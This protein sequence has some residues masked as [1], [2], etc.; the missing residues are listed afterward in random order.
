[1]AVSG[2]YSW[3]MC[4]PSYS[5]KVKAWGPTFLRRE[6]EIGKE[7]TGSCVYYRVGTVVPCDELR[8]SAHSRDFLTCTQLGQVPISHNSIFYTRLN[9]K[10]P[11][12]APPPPLLPPP[13]P[14]PPP[15]PT[16]PLTLLSSNIR[17][18]P[19]APTN[20]L[21]PPLSRSSLALPEP[22]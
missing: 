8:V 17:D 3:Y 19:P 7:G 9:Q 5:Y 1:M 18:F 20:S 4:T 2:M 6:K 14:P 13:P 22:A 12:A 16:P 11:Q 10:R 21:S 15:S